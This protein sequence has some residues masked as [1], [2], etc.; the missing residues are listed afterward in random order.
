MKKALISPMESVYI[1]VIG[2]VDSN[3]P[4]TEYLNN[5]AR[6]AEVRDTPFDVAPPLVWVDCDDTCNT[7][8]Y[9]FCTLDNSIKPLPPIPM[10]PSPTIE[11]QPSVSGA[12][13]L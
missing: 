8:Q 6:I 4:I 13:T 3:T 9:Y 5:Y 2:W 12:Q 7:Q 1:Q 10:P 11:D